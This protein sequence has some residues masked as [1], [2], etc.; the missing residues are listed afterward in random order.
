MKMNILEILPELRDGW[1][2]HA[3]GGFFKLLKNNEFSLYIAPCKEN[4]ANAEFRA[5]IG[6]YSKSPFKNPE[7]LKRK[8]SWYMDEYNMC[9]P[10]VCKE[11]AD[12]WYLFVIAEDGFEYYLEAARH[13]P[14]DE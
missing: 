13:V 10:I 9:R 6:L 7:R 14:E 4:S 5:E 12:G 8:F 1:Q 11:R 2:V 3:N